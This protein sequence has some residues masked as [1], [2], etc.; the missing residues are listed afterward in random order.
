MCWWFFCFYH[1]SVARTK[2]FGSVYNLSYGT[3][4]ILCLSCFYCKNMSACESIRTLAVEHFV[5]DHISAA[6]S[7]CWAFQLLEVDFFSL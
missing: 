4:M 6:K 5:A 2:C 3:L 7:I 1:A